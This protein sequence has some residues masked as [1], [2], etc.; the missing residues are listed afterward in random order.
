MRHRLLHDAGGFHHLRQEH[1]AA[2]EQI[3]DHV[4]AGHQRAFDHLD[5]PRHGQAGFLGVHFNKGVH[6]LDQRMFKPLFHRPR[7]PQFGSR[8][9][10]LLR[11]ALELVGHGQQAIGRIRAAVE[12]HVLAQFAQFRIDGVIH[13]KLP[14]VDDAHVH[15]RLDG[16][17]QKHAVHGPAHRFVAA[18]TERQVGNAA[19]DMGVRAT[20]ADLGASLDEINAVVVMF[21]DARRHRENVGI[22]DDIFRREADAGEQFVG[23]FTDLD[24][25]GS[26]VGLALFVEGH[27][28]HGSAITQALL[29]LSEE[30]RFAF[31]HADRIDDALAGQ[32]LQPGFDHRPFRG[33]DHHR[34]PR[35]VRL[36][37][38]QVQIGDHGRFAVEQAF[39]HVDVDDLRAVFHLLAR[40]FHG[41]RVIAIQ[42][43][44]LERSRSGDVGA[45][46]DVDEGCSRHAANLWASRPVRYRAVSGWGTTRGGRP[47]T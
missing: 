30:R 16:M 44:L 26:S 22:E 19:R 4:H 36:G 43:Q 9:G 45:L 27:H 28:H 24:L 3:S 32:A 47:A 39:V 31:L 13:V 18:E 35:D 23:A 41:R 34:H 17:I 5:R 40:D 11:P 14:G 7:P 46:T 25:A 1:L 12:N 21:L 38:D 2:A 10:G 33:I 8:I 20:L 15:A 42:D 37:R 29:R 6:A